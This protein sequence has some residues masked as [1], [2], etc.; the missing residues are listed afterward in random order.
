MIGYARSTL[1]EQGGL[2]FAD[3]QTYDA[4][5]RDEITWRTG[6]SRVVV[7]IDTT[8]RWDDLEYGGFLADD[9]VRELDS[10]SLATVAGAERE[11][12]HTWRLTGGLYLEGTLEPLAASRVSRPRQAGRDD[13]RGPRAHRS[14][15]SHRQCC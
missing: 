1:E 5:F 15:G 14:S 3:R 4:Q 7:G 13:G 6:V 8:A 10:P 9:G 11:R 2:R 12:T